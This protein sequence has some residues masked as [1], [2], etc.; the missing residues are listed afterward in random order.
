MTRL[1]I[2][3]DASRSEVIRFVEPKPWSRRR[4]WLVEPMRF[5]AHSGRA[6][7]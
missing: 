4:E 7:A 3:P 2:I 1:A 6:S 5:V